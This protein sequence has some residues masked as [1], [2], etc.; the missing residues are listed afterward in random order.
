MS[1]DANTSFL[2]YAPYH[3]CIF[4][5][6]N[7]LSIPPCSSFRHGSPRNTSPMQITLWTPKIKSARSSRLTPHRPKHAQCIAHSPS[8][9]HLGLSDSAAPLVNRYRMFCAHFSL[10]LTTPFFPNWVCGLLCGIYT[11]HGLGEGDQQ[12]LARS[13][14]QTT[15]Q[16]GAQ[17]QCPAT[18]GVR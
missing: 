12:I 18:L 13:G 17:P 3:L 4:L 8:A 11:D 5:L 6:R 16:G 9:G 10:L 14:P 2:L 7:A 1:F 15:P